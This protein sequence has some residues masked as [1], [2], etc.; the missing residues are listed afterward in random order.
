MT[1]YELPDRNCRADCWEA[2]PAGPGG[3]RRCICEW[4]NDRDE[5]YWEEPSQEVWESF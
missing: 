1:V 2:Q 5:A 4:L 3:A